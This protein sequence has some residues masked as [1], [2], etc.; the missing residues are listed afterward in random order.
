[1]IIPFPK[2]VPHKAFHISD[3]WS[4]TPDNVEALPAPLSRYIH[5]LQTNFGDALRENFQLA[6]E[7]AMLKKQ[8]KAKAGERK[9]ALLAVPERCDHTTVYHNYRPHI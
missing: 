9:L 6:Q 5:D 4:R 7:T 2:A 8:I 3:S 1:M